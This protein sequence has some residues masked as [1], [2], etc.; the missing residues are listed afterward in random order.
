MSFSDYL[1]RPEYYDP[2]GNPISGDEYKEL[3][4]RRYE[5]LS[6]RSWWRRRTDLGDGV[7]VSTAWLGIDHAYMGP[8]L[9]WETMILRE[10]DGRREWHYSSREAAFAHHEWVVTAL[11]QGTDPDAEL[12]DSLEAQRGESEG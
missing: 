12:P 9:F 4:H 8:P 10:G 7:C 5:D 6:D 1:N 3:F 2:D 11:R